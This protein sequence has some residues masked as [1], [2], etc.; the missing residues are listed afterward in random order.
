MK[1]NP[2]DYCQYNR[3]REEDRGVRQR[4]GAYFNLVVGTAKSLFSYSDDENQVHTGSD[5]E[6]NPG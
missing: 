4:G 5:G 6:V 1:L 3:G 2:G